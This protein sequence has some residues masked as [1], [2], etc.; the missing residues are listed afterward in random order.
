[1]Q[2]VPLSISKRLLSCLLP[3]GLALTVTGAYASG[4]RPVDYV[5]PLVGTDAHGHTYPGAALPFG[6]V[7]LSPDTH[8]DDWDGCSG[9]HYRDTTIQGFSH[10]HLSGTGCGCLGDILLMPTVGEVHLEAGTPGNGYSSSF[11]HGDEVA[12]AGYYKV[13]LKD[14]KVL[15]ELTATTRVGLHRY[16]FPESAESHVVID[17]LHG[18]QND[19]YDTELKVVNETTLVG[20]RKSSGWGGRRAVYFTIQ[21]SKPFESI[22]LEENGHRLASGAT[23][24]TGKVKAFV[25]YATHENEAIEVKVA[26]SATGIDGS[27]K[28]LAQELPGWDFAA[29]RDAAA[30][31][32]NQALGNVAV[33]SKNDHIKTTFYTNLY[34][35][36]QAPALFNDV[37]G[38]YWGSDHK[39]HTGEGF[40]NYTTFSLWDTYRALH[41]MLTIFQPDRVNNL[42]RSLLAEYDQSGLH[43]T[44]IWPLWGNETFCMV[45][46]HSVPVIV[47]AYFKGF[48]GFDAEKAYQ[49]MR[50]TAMQDRN[51][52]RDYKKLGY[53]A[54]ARGEQA[55]SKTLEYAYDDWCI[56]KMADA[57][58]HKD[59]AQ[60][61]YQRAANYR[62]LFDRST[63]FMR[64]RKADGTWRTPID[65]HG[66]VGDE[67]T[68]ADPWQ[69]A[70]FVQHDIPGLAK[71]FGGDKPFIEKL[72]QLFVEDSTIHTGIPDI[73]GLIGQFSQGDEQCHH[74]A[75]LYD[76]VGQPWKTQSRVREVMAKFYNDTPSGQCGNVDCGQMAAWYV[77]S[78]LG[79]YPVNPASGVYML[80][81]TLVD[82][83]TIKVPN[84]KTFTILADN[85]SEKNMY[86]QSIQLNGK[87][88]NRVWFTHNELIAGGTLH[89]VMGPRPNTALGTAESTR[90][91]SVMPAD[92]RLAA[93]PMPSALQPAPKAVVLSLPIRVVLGSDDPVG[94]FVPDPNLFEGSTNSGD[95][96]V[97]TSAAN[98]GPEAI[99]KSER[100][101][102]DLTY[103]Y[104]VP[105]NG[106]YTVRL[107]F[108]EIFDDGAGMR[109]EDVEL[110]GSSVLADFDIFKEAGGKNKALVRSFTGIKPDSKGRITIRVSASKDSPDQNAKLC[111]IE[112]LP[113]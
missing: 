54:S 79:F 60:M 49:A 23:E 1:M 20:Y 2:I 33:E 97:D 34:E 3:A 32:W 102:S 28:N 19:A 111:A 107:H 90:P 13:F 8:T 43:T 67:Y 58:G 27:Q 59:D 110:N 52:L 50:D 87:A 89:L 73:S 17:L 16:T 103:K 38:A 80:G 108:A 14:P 82:K 24:A 75:Y 68:E 83:A 36:Y 18:I 12:R 41:P 46:Y 78:S 72:D 76:L 40:D 112:I 29:T 53:V 31:S 99:Y 42:V 109:K 26:I 64:G 35:S 4:P 44:P 86:I 22:G 100:Y 45:G 15:A 91:H 21:F 51:G 113:Q 47:D 71:A 61:F 63:G 25:N 65:T 74:V 10:T 77:F 6:L 70:F 96:N 104:Q 93:L 48:K 85:N 11:S 92:L 69:Y 94:N 57:L 84:G 98:A 62:N 106:L 66:M 81:S 88:L 39:V 7:Q 95:T 5:N 55:T 101:A 56:A 30:E 9:Y 105:A 37:D